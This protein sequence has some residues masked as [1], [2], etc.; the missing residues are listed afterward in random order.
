MENLK[1]LKGEEL[2][3]KFKMP[4]DPEL[5]IIVTDNNR[6]YLKYGDFVCSSFSTDESTALKMAQAAQW[7][8]FNFKP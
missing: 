3:L 4:K 7:A 8:A 6:Y 2:S 1:N 5:K